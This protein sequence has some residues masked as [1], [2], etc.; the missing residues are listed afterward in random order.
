MKFGL[1]Y[2]KKVL[3]ATQSTQNLPKI[4]N[5]R[6]SNVYIEF[7]YHFSRIKIQFH[8]DEMGLL[9]DITQPKCNRSIQRS[10][11]PNTNW[12]VFCKYNGLRYVHESFQ[13]FRTYNTSD[14]INL[15][16]QWAKLRVF[17][18]PDVKSTKDKVCD[19]DEWIKFCQTVRILLV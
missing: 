11:F 18:A 6:T 2:R 10:F 13:L 14:S 16:L 7:C 9:L 17:Y 5:C 15:V 19:W 1:M 12:F 3:V 8:P 4:F